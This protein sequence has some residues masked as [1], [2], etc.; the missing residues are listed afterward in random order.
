VKL[1]PENGPWQAFRTWTSRAE[2][3]TRINCLVVVAVVV[4]VT[5]RVILEF[6]RC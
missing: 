3:I 4:D 1:W 5:V 2:N 6:V